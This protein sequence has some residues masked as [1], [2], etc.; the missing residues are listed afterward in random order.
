MDEAKD[1]GSG[2]V[3]MVRGRCRLQRPTISVMETAESIL[4]NFRLITA[5]AI[6]MVV[7]S[8]VGLMWV[9]SSYEHHAGF[10][11]RTH[12]NRCA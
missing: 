3:L 1:R 10:S 5:T 4:D 11:Y 2:S 9:E 6:A 7:I 8:S 12:P